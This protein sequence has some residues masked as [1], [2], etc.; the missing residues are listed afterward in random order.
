MDI[1]ETISSFIVVSEQMLALAKNAE[2]EQLTE[3]ESKRRPEI[4]A[5]FSSLD[6]E[7]RQKNIPELKQA[8]EKILDIDN[9]IIS[10]AKES[11]SHA[12]EAMKKNSSARKAMS[13]YQNN[14]GL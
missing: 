6:Q 11:R 3:I 1:K 5:F 9:Q 10:L 8:I 7:A 2:W 14:T 12:V 4:E 13:E